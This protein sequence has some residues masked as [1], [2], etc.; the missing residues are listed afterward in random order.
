[1]LRCVKV[2]LHPEHQGEYF[3]VAVNASGV[4]WYLENH[5]HLETACTRAEAF[6]DFC[7]VPFDGVYT[8]EGSRN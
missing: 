3:L 1:M 5:F 6:A 8:V 7:G 4:V 2:Q